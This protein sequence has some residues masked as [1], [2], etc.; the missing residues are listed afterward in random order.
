V[1]SP[2]TWTLPLADGRCAAVTLA[3]DAI[4]VDV[5]DD[6]RLELPAV[7]M[8]LLAF[9]LERCAV[10]AGQIRAARALRTPADPS[11]GTAEMRSVMSQLRSDGTP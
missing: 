1:K 3:D 2:P 10:L 8:G 6:Q 4:T 7:D 5:S 9:G 11:S